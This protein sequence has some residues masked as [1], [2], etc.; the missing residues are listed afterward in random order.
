[1]TKQTFIE[2]EAKA[3]LLSRIEAMPKKTGI[4]LTE[5]VELL[6]AALGK[7]KWEARWDKV[8]K[9]LDNWI[10]LL[11]EQGFHIEFNEDGINQMKL[12]GYW[13]PFQFDNG[14]GMIMTSDGSE[15]KRETPQKI[16]AVSTGT[17]ITFNE[18]VTRYFS[19]WGAAL[20]A[21]DYERS[22]YLSENWIEW[23]AE[24]GFYIELSGEEFVW[25]PAE[26]EVVELFVATKLEMKVDG[27]SV[28][29]VTSPKR[30]PIETITFISPTQL[31][32][33]Y[34]TGEKELAAA[35]SSEANAYCVESLGDEIMNGKEPAVKNYNWAS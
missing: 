4:P 20:D 32:I 29:L 10:E 7:A 16:R 8:N 18:S 3:Q 2:A 30:P 11:S 13:R 33:V 26:D 6:Y 9:L 17:S 12:R 35:F 1:M 15:H 27:I 14:H 5:A 28:M 34:V 19:I 31:Q 25:I 24:N 22:N 21:E 23:L